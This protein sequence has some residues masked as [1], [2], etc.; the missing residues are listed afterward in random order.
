[1]VQ[2][3]SNLNPCVS[4]VAQNFSCTRP[5]S[6]FPFRTTDFAHLLLFLCEWHSPNLL[7]F[8]SDLKILVFLS[9]AFRLLCGALRSCAFVFP[10]GKLSLRVVLKTKKFISL[11]FPTWR[12]AFGPHDSQPA[13]R[14]KP[15]S[16]IFSLAFRYFRS[17]P[18]CLPFFLRSTAFIIQSHVSISF[19]N[20]S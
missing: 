20:I 13:Q 16:G 15:K 4:L 1:M 8:P 6:L 5:A 11:I 19:P 10:V 12:R 14:Q 9:A 17:R 3:V 2:H 7:H 18:L